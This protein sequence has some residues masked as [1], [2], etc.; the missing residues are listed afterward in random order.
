MIGFVAVRPLYLVVIRVFGWL[1]LLTRS[2]AAK[3]AE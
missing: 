2:D 3:T 1:M